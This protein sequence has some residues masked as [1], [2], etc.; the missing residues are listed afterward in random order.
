MRKCSQVLF[1]VMLLFSFNCDASEKEPHVILFEDTES[2]KEFALEI[3]SM[4]SSAWEKWQN[5]VI[6]SDIDVDG[7]QGILSPGDIK[8]PV[9]T[10]VDMLNEFHSDDQSSEYKRCV[11]AVALAVANGMR[12]WQRGYINGDIPFPQGTSCVYTLTPCYNVP[13]SVGSG[14]SSGD[15]AMTG[16]K[17]YSYMLYS[18]PGQEENVK[19][20]FHATASAIV[21]GFQKWRETCLITDI[22]A[23]GGVAPPPAPMGTGPGIVNGAKGNGGKLTG[24]SFD[25]NLMYEKMCEYYEAH[26]LKG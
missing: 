17:L 15:M 3:S 2:K 7:S 21:R 5:A 14:S 4:I 26:R 19:I 25:A 20:V 22:L 16:K 23:K 18:G 13:V 24:V 10:A 8:G 1:I 9:L 6:V 11:K 12:L